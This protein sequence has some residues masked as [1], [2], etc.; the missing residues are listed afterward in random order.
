MM[1]DQT[2]DLRGFQ[3]RAQDFKHD[4]AKIVP[5]AAVDKNGFVSFLN[6]IWVAMQAYIVVG[7]AEPIDS[8]RDLNRVQ[9]KI[10]CGV[11]TASP[12]FLPVCAH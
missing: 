4:I 9:V 10:F 6:Q 1:I 3:P 7:I 11:H 8:L 2:L 5:A 12:P